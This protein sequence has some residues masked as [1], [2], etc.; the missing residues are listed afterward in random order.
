MFYV[1]ILHSKKDGL[2]YTGFTSDLKERVRKHNAGYV[3][4]TKHRRP[5]ELLYYESYQEELD[6]KRREKYLKGG[7][8]KAGLKIQLREGFKKIGYKSRPSDL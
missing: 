3:I 8:G 6:A 1:Y 4:A 2:L 5:L 7:K